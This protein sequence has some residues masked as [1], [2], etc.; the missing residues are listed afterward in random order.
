MFSPKRYS[1]QVRDYIIKPVNGANNSEFNCEGF[2]ETEV[3][4]VTNPRRTY[5][6]K[7]TF[8]L[9]VVKGTIENVRWSVFGDPV[10]I[11]TCSWIVEHS[12]NKKIEELIHVVTPERANLD[13]DFKFKVDL[14]AGCYT[15]FS[16]FMDALRNY[17]PVA[18]FL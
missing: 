5:I 2:C 17:A 3:K 9:L 12:L 10:A 6:N 8:K 15:S 4:C 13:L 18:C 7:V 14:D 16:A 1:K 11:A